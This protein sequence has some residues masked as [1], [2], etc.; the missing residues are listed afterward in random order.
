MLF[1]SANL[2]SLGNTA[3]STKLI[4]KERALGLLHI[5]EGRIRHRVDQ[6]VLK[7]EHVLFECPKNYFQTKINYQV[8][9]QLFFAGDIFGA[10]AAAP[11]LTAIHLPHLFVEVAGAK[12]EEEIGV[13][14]D[15]RVALEALVVLWT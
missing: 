1:W 2:R 8:T 4:T 13:V 10:K 11:L 3:L 12:V 5:R 7:N 9:N 14:A 6:N 15:H